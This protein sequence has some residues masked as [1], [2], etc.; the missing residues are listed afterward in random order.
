M[1]N[2]IRSDSYSESVRRGIHP[3]T[4]TPIAAN[5][6]SATTGNVNRTSAYFPT[7]SN[8]SSNSRSATLSAIV[9]PAHSYQR[10]SNQQI[11]METKTKKINTLPKAKPPREVSLR[12][13]FIRLGEVNT[14]H[15]KFYAEVVIEARWLY[16]PEAASWNPNL[17]VKNALG[18]IKQ[19]VAHELVNNLDE[20]VFVGDKLHGIIYVWEIRKLVGTFWEK[21][22]LNSFPADVQQL[23][24]QIVARCPIEE[25]VLVENRF[26]PSMVN[27]EAF[28]AQQEWFLYEHIETRSTITTEDFSFRP[29]RQSTYL[30]TC[31]VARRPGYFYWNVYLLIFL[32]TLIALTVY[33]VAPE[34]PQ[35]RLQIT[36][37]LLLTSI[38]FR[39]SVSRLL[40]PVSYLTLLDKYTLVSLVF[41]SLNSI[42]HSVIG[43]LIRHM[44][45]SKII[46]YYVLSI[47]TAFFIIYHFLMALFLFQALRS[48]QVM[49]ES[50]RQ[51]AS[52]L[53]GMFE[54][55]VQGHHAVQRFQERQ[56]SSRT[57]LFV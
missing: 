15:E 38:M 54:T 1:S 39:W 24:L 30:V 14:L 46:D 17:Y 29:I 31:C 23:S 12:V 42:W 4:T 53:A 22:E 50:D 11:N 25:C 48:R 6:R 57:S 13:K 21:L 34:H 52:K 10:L 35:S 3:L 55:F 18:D 20:P 41:I 7:T 32:I 51:Y 44:G 16:D 56:N 33:G 36:C 19:E 37:T 49:L 47:F 9:T 45:I 40:P 26:Q 43:F 5:R 28:L 27:R 2:T 8:L